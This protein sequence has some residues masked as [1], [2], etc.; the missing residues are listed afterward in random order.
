MV[1]GTKRK[2]KRGI[3][4]N[5]LPIL[6]LVMSD[7]DIGSLLLFLARYKFILAGMHLG[8]GERTAL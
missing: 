6:I 3:D 8:R 2:I 4:F 5:V 7:V 1:G